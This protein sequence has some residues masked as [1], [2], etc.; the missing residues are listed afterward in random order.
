[1]R[2]STKLGLVVASFVVADFS[3]LYKLSNQ[4]FFD[5]TMG[6]NHAKDHHSPY[7]LI[8]N[9]NDLDKQMAAMHTS[10]NE[11]NKNSPSANINAI[12]DSNFHYNATRTIPT[13]NQLRLI[14]IA[15]DRGLRRLDD[16]GQLM[17]ILTQAGLDIKNEDDL[18]QET[19]D[20]L[21]T[22]T[23]I[24]NLYGPK[25]IILG[26]E[27]C[28]DF[29]NRVEPTTRYF[30]M[31]GT[32]N[33]GTN[34]I[35]D[36]MKFNC[37]IVERME[38]YGNKS[39]GVRWQVPWGKHYMARYRSSDHSTKSDRDVPKNNTLPLVAIRDPYSWMQS[40][41]RHS[42]TAHWSHNKAHC[43]NL[44]ATE[45]DIHN[46]PA[47]RK[48]YGHHRGDIVEGKDTEKLVPIKINYSNTIIH[49]HSSFGHWYSEWYND[50]LKADYP[51]IMVR[52]EDLLFYGKDVTRAMC[53]CGGG[54]PV[55]DN[56]RSGDFMH[57]SESAKKGLA[58]HGSI[59][60]RTNLVGALI[61]YGSSEHR[62]DS[63]TEDDLIA[64]RRHFD[65]ELMD[66]FGYRHP[67]SP[68]KS[69]PT[70]SLVRVAGETA[71]VTDAGRYDDDHSRRPV[72]AA[73]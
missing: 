49:N 9:G 62:T 42:Y 14:Q 53:R 32:F 73:N 54:I 40:M 20:L 55:P 12:N 13:A 19:I 67:P 2:R 15:K 35:A 5:E 58:A 39:K 17:E 4:L 23:R 51:R 60:M 72:D 16:K 48:M 22:W 33:T 45:D 47:L 18:D 3:F 7:N 11:D 36:L 30:G 34:L 29:R 68:H 38:V 71:V 8:I 27:R 50:Y 31:A 44:I 63:M 28:E 25:P 6:I 65:P 1:M 21:P 46:L 43:P 24:K 41:C 59:K 61:K 69:K 64:A 56:G 57:V 52:F 26:L 70:G 37:E 10:K 66:T